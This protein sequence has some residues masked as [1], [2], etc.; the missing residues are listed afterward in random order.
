MMW[1][2]GYQAGWGVLGGWIGFCFEIAV[3]AALLWWRLRR[4]HWRG[5]AERSRREQAVG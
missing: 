4:E 1:L 2:L 3:G 5:A